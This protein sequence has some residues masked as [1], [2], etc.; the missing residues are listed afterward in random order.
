MDK[1]R[2]GIIG[3]GNQG[4]LYA[5]FITEG[6]VKDTVVGAICDIDPEKKKLA[7]EKY[8][9]IPFYDNYLDMLDSGDVDAI[10]TTVPHYLHPEMAIE[11]LKRGIHAMVE[12]PAGVYTKQVREMNEFAATKPDVTFAIMFNQRTNP[13]YI[14]VRELVQSGEL[15]ELRRVNWIITD[16]W[17]PQ[18]YYDSG[19]WRATWGGEGGGVLVN[20]APHQIDMLQW[21]CGMPKKV[22][23]KARYGYH[24]DIVVE[25]DVTA[26]FDFENGATGV[27]TTCTHDIVGTNRLEIYGDLGKAI[28][29]N[30]KL[31]VKKLTKTEQELS[32]EMDMRTIYQL[33]RGGDTSSLYTEEVFEFGNQWGGQHVAVLENFAA[34]ILHGTPLIADGAEGIRGVELANAMLLSSWLDKEVELPLDEEVYFEEL[35]KR[36]KEENKYPTR[37]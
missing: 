30:G 37:D 18:T 28:V 9:S 11:S 1:V 25:N 13:L 3:F 7:Q 10:V 20:Q 16:W 22:Y 2:L 17:R 33:V 21:I 36:I 6:K 19:T 14:K 29:E 34:N 32:K 5:Q 12:K 35:N 15:G 4:S 26:V 27:F 24:R 31:V 8:P 23:A